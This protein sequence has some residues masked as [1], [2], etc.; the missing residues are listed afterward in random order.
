[1]SKESN[2]FAALQAQAD[3]IGWPTSFESDLNHD[4]N[5]I[6]A[7]LPREPFAWCLRPDGTHMGLADKASVSAPQRLTMVMVA[8]AFRGSEFRWFVWDGNSLQSVDSPGAADSR[9]DELAARR[10]LV[11]S[12]RKSTLVAC[13]MADRAS[14]DRLA[15]DWERRYGED[16]VVTDTW[17]SK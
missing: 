2:A 17:G 7:M 15:V 1:M 9:I 10:Y 13:G 4:R 3:V 12:R 8:E 5:L 6:A 14:A 16:F 11:S